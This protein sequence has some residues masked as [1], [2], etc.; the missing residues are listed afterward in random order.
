MIILLE[1]I[2]VWE[3]GCNDSNIFSDVVLVC[4]SVSVVLKNKNAAGL[5]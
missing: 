4:C 1:T 5:F 3:M 2:N